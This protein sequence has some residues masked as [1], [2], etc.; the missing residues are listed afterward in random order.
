[1]DNATRLQILAAQYA[2]NSPDSVVGGFMAPGALVAIFFLA[3][4]VAV[5]ILMGVIDF[6]T[7]QP[8]QYY[9]NHDVEKFLDKK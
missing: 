5:F 2:G 1:M 8:V 6:L 9:E 3:F 4:I 7:E